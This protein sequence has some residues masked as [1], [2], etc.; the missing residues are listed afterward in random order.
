MGKKIPFII[1][2]AGNNM[3]GSIE[4]AK[5]LISAALDNGA[6]AVKF[7][8]GHAEDFARY[9]KQIPF[10]KK[11]DLG[12]EGYKQLLFYGNKIGMPVFFSVWS[13]DYSFLW[14]YE[15]YHKL[16]AR[17]FSEKAIL[18]YD[19]PKTFISIPYRTRYIQTYGIKHSTPLHCVS[20]YPTID[21]HLEY[22]PKLRKYL[23]MEVGYSDHTIGI[24]ACVKAVQEYGAVAIEKHFTLAHDYGVLRDHSISATPGQ[25]DELVKKVK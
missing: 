24:N 14:E 23:N 1:A 19:T 17:Q 15:P 20:K 25:L 5:E 18:Q 9:K 22:I 11:Y 12:R 3:E 8:A 21:P 16:A 6:D 4:T 13:D 10:Y 7:Q 2:E